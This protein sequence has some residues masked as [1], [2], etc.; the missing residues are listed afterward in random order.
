MRLVKH[1][2]MVVVGLVFL[3]VGAG[4]SKPG[5]GPAPLP[6]QPEC[7]TPKDCVGLP[8]ILCLGQWQCIDG[9][10]QWQCE[11]QPK[12]CYSDQDCPEGQ[13]CSVSD[14][15]CKQSPSCP[16]CTVCYGECVPNK[17]K[18]VQSG[19]SGEVCAPEPVYTICIWKPWYA[20]LKATKC[21]E[22]GPNGSCGFE[23]TP[24]FIKCIEEQ[25][26]CTTD[27]DC[28]L[29]FKCKNES[30]CVDS[31]AWCEGGGK[32]VIEPQEVECKTDKDCKEGQVCKFKEEC[33]PCVYGNPPCKIACVLKGY[34]AEP[35]PIPP[36]ECKSDQDCKPGYK[37]M[38]DYSWCKNIY[39]GDGTEPCECKPIHICKP[40]ETKCEGD[41]DC[42]PGYYC[43]FSDA[44]CLDCIGCPCFGKCKPVKEQCK[45]DKDCPEGYKCDFFAVCPPCNCPEG[46][47]CKCMPCIIPDY[48]TCV[49]CDEPGCGIKPECQTDKDCAPWEFCNF[50]EV[51]KDGQ[52][53]EQ[54]KVCIPE[55]PPCVGVCDM[56]PGYCWSDADCKPGEKC[57]GAIIC[58]PGAYCIIAD[59]PGKCVVVGEK[60]KTDQDC[61]PGEKCELKEVCPPCSYNN[62]PCLLPCFVEGVCVPLPG[63]CWT[64]ADCKEGEICVGAIK[65]PPGAMCFVADKLGKCVPNAKCESD[66]D[67]PPGQFCDLKCLDGDC[68]GTCNPL[69]EGACVKD[70]DCAKG[71]ICQFGICPMCVGCPCF[72][73]CV[74]NPQCVPVKPGTHGMC[75]ML[76]GIIFDGKQC[77]W[78]SG[79]SCGADCPYFFKDFK[80]CVDACDPQC[81]TDKDCPPGFYCEVVK[82]GDNSKC[83]GPYHCK[84]KV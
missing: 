18:C 61:L 40:F 73:K 59:K 72:G 15:D 50:L 32:C 22:F 3:V 26:N 14:G 36:E 21:G 13:H 70:A 30:W 47:L 58:P 5:C 2:L 48:G 37:C 6:V 25:V 10:C 84:P 42:E 7:T 78:E 62:P 64:D 8:H 43:D 1:M 79:C 74:G 31:G 68:F 41:F 71:Q 19:C 81:W 45:T 52:C 66:K 67:C 60:C 82:C 49:P 17:P 34:C 23:Q 54:G 16:G 38:E 75:E 11:N 4:P 69:P 28:P 77:V 29:G 20:C 44:I 80:S 56:K 46:A 12:G 83:I 53:C 9:S 33:P 65:C 55:I 35:E 51:N 63:Y 39:C 57:E 24:E 27:K 76:L